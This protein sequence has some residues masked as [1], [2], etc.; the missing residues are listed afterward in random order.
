MVHDQPDSPALP[1][2]IIGCAVCM[3]MV[4]ELDAM[5][6]VDGVVPQ[7]D[8]VLW[9]RHA[10]QAHLAHLPAG[11]PGGLLRL[12]G[13]AGMERVAAGAGVGKRPHG[14]RSPAPGHARAR[15]AVGLRGVVIRRWL[16]VL[17]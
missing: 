13:L 6:A 2:W 14:A 3:R 15:R 17:I 9:Q 4:A 1:G 7:A 10:V 8:L 5:V 11:V 12:S 16:R